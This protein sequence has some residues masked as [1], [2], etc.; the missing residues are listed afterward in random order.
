MNGYQSC[1]WWAAFRI[2]LYWGDLGSDVLRSDPNRQPVR[3]FQ[4]D[5]N[6]LTCL[7]Y[8]YSSYHVRYGGVGV[9]VRRRDCLLCEVSSG[10]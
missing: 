4:G 6:F 7:S 10:Q 2:A 5:F 9:R 1:Q 3:E 8:V